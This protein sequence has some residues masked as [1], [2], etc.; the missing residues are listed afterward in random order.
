MATVFIPA[1]M[2]DLCGGRH[3]VEVAGA[4]LRQVLSNLDP[5]CPGLHALVVEDGMVRPG[6][7]LAVNGVMSATGLLRSVPEDAEVQILPAL[8][9]G[10]RS[11]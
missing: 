5:E 3:S 4:T 7:Q 10:Q 2:R 9:G 6:I 8:S 11:A 1:L